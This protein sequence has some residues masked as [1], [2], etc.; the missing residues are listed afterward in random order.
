MPPTGTPISGPG[1]GG[2]KG[3]MIGTRPSAAEEKEAK[4]EDKRLRKRER[5]R[6]V[7]K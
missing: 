7:E 4:D 5:V 1:F 6:R 2:L 3:S